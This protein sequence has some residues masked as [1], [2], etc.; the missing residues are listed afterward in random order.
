MILFRLG[1]SGWLFVLFLILF[2]A[3]V[4][5]TN[6]QSSNLQI[7]RFL[8]RPSISIDS[9]ANSDDTTALYVN[10]AG[11]SIHPLQ[12]GYFYGRN[13]DRNIEDHTMFLNLFGIAFSTQW[14]FA[15][16]SETIRRYTL[17]TGL[18]S[19][20]LLSL[21]FSF[22][23]FDS[24]DP[25]LDV[26]Q[27]LDLG[28]IL[29]P[30]RSIS[31]GLVGRNLTESKIGD[32]DLRHRWDIGFSL[33]PIA[34]LP[35]KDYADKFTLSIETTWV[36][37]R[38]IRTLIPRYMLEFL[39][40]DGFNFYTG[41]DH[42]ENFFMGMRFS[43]SF[44]QLSLQG[45]IP[46]INESLSSAIPELPLN[47]GNSLNVGLLIGQ[48]RFKNRFEAVSYLLEISLDQISVEE[49][50]KPAL[51]FFSKKLTFYDTLRAVQL[52]QFDPQ[53]NGILIRGRKFP[54]GW[55]QAEELRAAL[56]K[57]KRH[58]SKPVIGFLEEMHNKEY[59]IAS[60]ADKLSM[61][62]AGNLWLNGLKAELIFIKDLLGKIGVKADFI[63]IGEYKTAPDIFQRSS[64]RQTQEE[65]TLKILD[66][67]STELKESILI[68]RGAR[69][70]HQKIDKI[71]DHGIYRASEAKRLGLI[72]HE[73]YLDD[74]TSRYKKEQN[75]SLFLK[76]SIQTYV[77]TSNYLDTWGPRPRIV[78][79][80][81]EGTILSD[82]Q[83]Q[84]P[85]QR[86]LTSSADIAKKIRKLRKSS[87]VKGIVIRVN[88]PGGSALAS[89]IIWK[90]ISLAREAGKLL[91]ISLG[92]TAASGGY[93]V[94]MAGDH[95]FA[96]KNSITGS[97]GVFS[98]KFSLKAL[99]KLLG[100]HKTVYTTSKRSAIFSEVDEFTESERI[101]IKENL[102]GFYD[103]FLERVVT[104]RAHLN[105][106]QV[107]QNAGGR[108]YTGKDALKRKMVDQIG[109][110]LVALEIMKQRLGLNDDYVDIEIYPEDSSDPLGILELTDGLL[111]PQLVRKSIQILERSR[112]FEEDRIHFLLP[113]QIEIE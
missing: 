96:N 9:V 99:Y 76:K 60:A 56:V 106:Q 94:S 108:V 50:V 36:V 65:Q 21:G 41:I 3:R 78:I 19:T 2:F 5:I 15:P 93:Y 59:Y 98:G 38:N 74:L 84:F 45:N 27:S 104:N 88:S 25:G 24:T 64:P 105:V 43:Q 7:D 16:D 81:I 91:M 62:S 40:I 32:P 4:G 10:P 35:L 29:R 101:L 55:G 69:I 47:D 20:E 77:Q 39:P 52:A 31:I 92:D 102:K 113:Y 34:Y 103:L 23:W 13:V 109:G 1:G 49:N 11:L 26:H 66:D 79:V 17:G 14:R 53:I 44:Y 48:E 58:S 111:L 57:F 63:Q 87:R 6:A 67:I 42:Q 80:V 75:L 33:R 83:D 12:A 70:D 90:E 30:H 28:L 97:I 112:Q 46:G 85:I 61:P 8:L 71:M 82:N 107:K 73:E 89:D 72:D 18:G 68:G 37:D 100:V 22:T 54:G 110:L 95:I 51:P 86:K